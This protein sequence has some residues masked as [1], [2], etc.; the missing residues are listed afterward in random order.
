VTPSAW[1]Q[2]YKIIGGAVM[3]VCLIGLFIIFLPAILLIAWI[4][5]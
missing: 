4:K 1:Y 2:A 5:R 3:G